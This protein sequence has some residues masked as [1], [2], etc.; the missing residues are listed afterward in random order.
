MR[1]LAAIITGVPLT[2]GLDKSAVLIEP[3]GAQADAEY[4]RHLADGQLWLRRIERSPAFFFEHRDR[5]S[6]G[7]VS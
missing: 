1:S 3:Q 6:S 2:A 4:T 7:S 5:N